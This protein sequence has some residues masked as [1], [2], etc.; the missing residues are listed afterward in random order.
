MGGRVGLKGTDGEETVREAIKM[1][2]APKVQ[3]R[4]NQALEALKNADVQWVTS[5]G[6][7]GGR[8]PEWT[9]VRATGTR[10]TVKRKDRSRV[11]NPKPLSSTRRYPVS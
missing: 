7:M 4:A 9:R 8:R 1:G 3:E 6:S 2:A 5:G 11:L 10:R